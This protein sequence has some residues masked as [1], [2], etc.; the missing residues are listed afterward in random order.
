MGPYTLLCEE[1]IFPKSQQMQ[2]F[3]HYKCNKCL[4]R[5]TWI[6]AL[7]TSYVF[8]KR[9]HTDLLKLSGERLWN[10][11]TCFRFAPVGNVKDLNKW[12]QMSLQYCNWTYVA[13][14]DN[15]SSNH[16]SLYLSASVFYSLTI[17]LSTPTMLNP[18]QSPTFLHHNCTVHH[19]WIIND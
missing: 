12:S 5:Q 6:S 7:S 16:V 17:I 3:L 1:N 18:H 2:E 14:R 10:T 15:Q 4:S 19:N 11:G 8:G 13:V 9:S